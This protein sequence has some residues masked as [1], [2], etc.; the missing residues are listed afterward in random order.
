MSSLELKVP[1]PVLALCFALLMWL[2]AKLVYPVELPFGLRVGIAIVLVAAGL[3]VG[4]AGVVSFRRART[5][6]NPTKPTATTSLVCGGIYRFTRNPMYLGLA[7]YLL[8]WAA[9]LS[10]ILALLFVPL[11]VGYINRF[12]INPEERALLAL[13]GG[14]YTAYKHGVRRWL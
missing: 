8:A 1:P 5:T 14:E 3:A 7:L 10:N 9:F 6:I 2:A 12:Q 13:F 4:I 11:F